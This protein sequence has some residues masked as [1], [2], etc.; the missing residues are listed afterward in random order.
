[1]PAEWKTRAIVDAEEYRNMYE[2]SVNDPENF[3]RR[4]GLRIDWI[5]PYT[6][7]KNTSFAKDNVSIK[8]FEDGTLNVSAPTAS[9]G[10]WQN[11]GEQTAI[12]W[13]GDDPKRPKPITYRQAARPRSAR[14]ANVL[15]ALGVKRGD[16]VTLYL[17]MILEGVVAMLACARLGAVHSVVFGGFSPEALAGRI[18][19]CGSRFVITADEGLRGGKRVPLK[20]NVDAALG[21]AAHATPV[22]GGAG[23]AATLAATLRCRKAATTGWPILPAN[24]RRLPAAR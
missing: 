20:A 4:E 11:A 17:P 5:K 16:R 14:F 1:M 24:D 10:I 19:D 8:W 18:E 6:K 7:I 13:E 9:T 22:D 23:G 21:L 3:W 12:I 2:A 15:K